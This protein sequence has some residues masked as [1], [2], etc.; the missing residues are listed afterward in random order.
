MRFH[1]LFFCLSLPQSLLRVAMENEISVI[2][3]SWRHEAEFFETIRVDDDAVESWFFFPSSA[4]P[5]VGRQRKSFLI[6]SAK[7]MPREKTLL[8][9]FSLLICDDVKRR[10]HASL[11]RSCG[12]WEAFCWSQSHHPSTMIP[13]WIAFLHLIKGGKFECGAASKTSRAKSSLLLCDSAASSNLITNC[14]NYTMLFP[15]GKCAVIE[16]RR[17]YWTNS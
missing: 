2:K 10:F 17:L 13:Q 5:W 16:S 15:F 7:K 8:I 12:L 6:M 14:V 1:L 3:F 9:H 4:T 11:R